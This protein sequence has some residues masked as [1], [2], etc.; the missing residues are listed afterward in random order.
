MFKNVIRGEN[1]DDLKKFIYHYLGITNNINEGLYVTIGSLESHFSDSIPI[2]ENTEILATVEFLEIKSELFLETSLNIQVFWQQYRQVLIE[3][4]WEKIENYPVKF[5]GF[6]ENRTSG[7]RYCHKLHDFTL[8]ITLY[9]KSENTLIKLLAQKNNNPCK[10]LYPPQLKQDAVIPDL[11]TPEGV[12]LL[13]ESS[14][15]RGMSSGGTSEQGYA[16]I[17]SGLISELKI[18]QIFDGYNVQL[19][20]LNWQIINRSISNTSSIS[21]WQF[22]AEGQVWRAYLI[23]I[24][25]PLASNEYSIWLH[26]YYH[27]DLAGKAREDVL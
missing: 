23:L 13:P 3:A 9:E 2:P 25:D 12:T 19:E 4:G 7:W 5:P 17:S 16:T 15:R 8:T 6:T 21:S 20:N 11:R 22:D 26:M 18:S 1:I 24:A 10:Y 27:P 14:G